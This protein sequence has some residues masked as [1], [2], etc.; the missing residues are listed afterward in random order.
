MKNKF[1]EKQFLF[2][3]L[4]YIIGFGFIATISSV[5]SKGLW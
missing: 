3:G 5:V 4:N 1:T 2:Y